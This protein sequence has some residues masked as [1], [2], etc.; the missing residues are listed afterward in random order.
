M[1]S[2]DA[3]ALAKAYRDGTR[4][5]V[6]VL[7]EAFARIAAR[8]DD[9]VWI[10]L[11]ARDR[12]LD[13]A[14]AL[15]KRR[16][17]GEM[18]PLYGLPFAVK[19]NIDVAGLPTTAACPAFAYRPAAHAH[20]VARLI[21]AG[22]LVVGKTNLDQFA[23]GLVGVRSPYGVPKNLLDERFIVGGSSSGSGVAV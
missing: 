12:V 8:G 6:D 3:A 14:R 21:A 16:A 13:D 7:E 22:A 10:A 19:D 9:G 23:T 1:Q 18:L 2:F 17:A 5:P 20:V 4:T 11:A 15:E